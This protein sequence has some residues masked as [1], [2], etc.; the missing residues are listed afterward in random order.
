[1][2]VVFLPVTYKWILV[3]VPETV[4]V[5]LWPNEYGGLLP[6]LL[7][8]LFKFTEGWFV[9]SIVGSPTQLAPRF[10]AT[11]TLAEARVPRSQITAKMRGFIVDRLI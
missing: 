4:A 7:S 2:F 6:Q 10:T 9:T 5:K 8:V 3:K 11:V 1:M